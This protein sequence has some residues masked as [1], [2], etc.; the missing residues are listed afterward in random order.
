MT[1]AE[2][3]SSWLPAPKKVTPVLPAPIQ[4]YYT[5]G[6]LKPKALPATVV[7]AYYSFPSKF[8]EETYKVWIRRFLENIPCHMVFFTERELEP[9]IRSCRTAYEDKTHIVVLDKSEWTASKAFPPEFWESQLALDPEKRTANHTPDLYKI[10]Y[11]KKEFVKRAIELNPFNHDD[12]VW[13]DAGIFR[14]EEL[15]HI[16]RFY[17]DANRVPT[18]RVL[19]LNY[20]PF[21][22]EDVNTDDFRKKNRIGGGVIAANKKLWYTWSDLYDKTVQKYIEQK[23]FVGKDQSIMASLFLENKSLVSIVRPCET[24]LN[25]W[26]YLLMYLG[27]SDTLYR[28]LHQGKFLTL[29]QL[30]VL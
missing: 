13:T 1:K 11:E 9:F 17:P 24:E 28:E 15:V 23:K 5:Q 6:T 22:T 10:W 12:F 29:S 3:M 25:K 21:T 18:D 26:L 19:L 4:I 14:N 30:K 7:S 27:S 20:S 16:A 8:S 2:R